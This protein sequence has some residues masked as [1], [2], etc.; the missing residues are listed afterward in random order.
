M[1]IHRIR[2]IAG[3]FV[4]GLSFAL[5]GG[6]FGVALWLARSPLRSTSAPSKNPSKNN[7][8]R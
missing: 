1:S 6:A 4:V 7:V 2:G 3:A 8:R 5:A